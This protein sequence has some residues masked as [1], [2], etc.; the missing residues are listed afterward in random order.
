MRV[1]SSASRSPSDIAFSS[2]AI[3]STAAGCCVCVSS[4]SGSVGLVGTVGLG[5]F[6]VGFGCLT[7]G[8]FFV[9]GFFVFA[10]VAVFFGASRVAVPPVRCERKKLL[11]ATLLR[12]TI[13]SGV[14]IIFPLAACFEIV[15]RDTLHI[16]ENSAMRT[17]LFF[18]DFPIL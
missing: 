2:S 17:M 10:G 8:V 12:S 11:F 1:F 4:S 15:F 13:L 5:C 16:R 18:S 3:R 7:A 9:A 14:K 6:A